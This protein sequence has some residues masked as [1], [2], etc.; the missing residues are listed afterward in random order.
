[1]LITPIVSYNGDSDIVLKIL[2]SEREHEFLARLLTNSFI[3]CLH[4]YLTLL[5]VT[6]VGSDG[7][8]IVGIMKDVGLTYVSFIV[9]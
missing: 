7:I 6:V 5:T 2:Q 4:T 1:M 3:C 9:F 8:N